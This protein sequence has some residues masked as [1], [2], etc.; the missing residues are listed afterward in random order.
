MRPLRDIIA[1]EAAL[2]GLVD[3]RRRE[4]TV[5]DLLQ[6]N[7]PPAL[8]A[9]TGVADAS[10]RELVLIATSGAA[11]TLLRHRGPELLEALAREGWKFTGIRVRVQARAYRGNR[12]KV[13]AKQMDE[14]SARAL[15]SCAER[16]AD[17]R[18]AAALRR[19]AARGGP[20]S[21]DEQKSLEGVEDEHPEQKD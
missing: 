16:L 19:L 18:L 15:R 12:S 1:A 6:K 5:L 20:G 9:Q 17:L 3:R 14:R 4:L 13:H 7:L 21:V 11:A 8:A 10:P 2:A